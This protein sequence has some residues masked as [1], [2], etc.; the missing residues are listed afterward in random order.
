MTAGVLFSCRCT[1][2]LARAEQGPK[3]PQEKAQPRESGTFTECGF[4]EPHSVQASA[5][6]WRPK[7]WIGASDE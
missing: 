3:S 2:I 5:V 1:V 4:W 7:V 6:G